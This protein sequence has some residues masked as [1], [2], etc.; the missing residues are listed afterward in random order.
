[1]ET[2]VLWYFGI[3]SVIAI[4]LSLAI[5]WIARNIE[6]D[7]YTDLILGLGIIIA[8]IAWPIIVMMGILELIKF[9]VWSIRNLLNS[10]K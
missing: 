8:F 5:Y 6:I 4:I 3:G 1:M 10:G 7:S 2:F 9:A